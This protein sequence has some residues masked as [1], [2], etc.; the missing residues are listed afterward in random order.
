MIK[1][2]INKKDDKPLYV[3]IRDQLEQA[4]VANELKPGDKLPSVAVLAKEIGVTQATIRRALEDLS[5]KGYTKCHVGRGT[6][7]EDTKRTAGNPEH[8][9]FSKEPQEI[10]GYGLGPNRP[11]LRY[12]ARRMRR[13]VSEGLLELMNLAQQQGL[14]S[15]A[16]GIPDPKLHEPDFLKGLVN[17]AFK[18]DPLKYMAYSDCQGLMEL[19]CEIASRY[20]KKG[21]SVS[22]EQILITN[23]SQQAAAL[24]A[25]ET[26][27]KKQP[28]ICEAPSF[29]GI[30]ETFLA[31]GN[32]VDTVR[33]D[34]KGP[35]PEYL[36]HFTGHSYLLY[37]CPELHN[38][39]GTDMS[40]NRH[41]CIVKW[42]QNTKSTLLVDDIFQD[43]R[44]GDSPCKSF[45]TTLGED[46]TILI[47]SLSKTVMSGLRVGWMISS[48]E[49]IRAFTRLKRLMDQTC[50]PLMQGIVTKLFQTGK[51]DDH[52]NRILSIYQDR[53]NVMIESLKQLM[54]ESVTWTSPEGGFSL[55][56]TLPEGYSS[57]ALLLAAVDKGINF[58]PGP[59]FDIDQRFVKSFRLTWA[60][61]NKDEI[62]EGI[63]ILA[64]T[65]KELLRHSPGNLG[66]SG[67]GNFQ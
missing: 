45:I 10:H 8:P 3:Q 7:I 43:L 64:D 66:L 28:V 37:V 58:L 9:F 41:D 51:Y 29:Q 21:I 46:Q 27:E 44:F 31:H 62:A 4:I 19:R 12:A 54:P 34:E 33:R 5:K 52:L 38:P 14:I 25:M 1:I 36:N 18:E 22:P 42:A 26:A 20:I 11:E 17:D 24:V 57:I 63:E 2:E 65:V 60:W 30:T 35:N 61:V 55:W 59:L 50:P 56:V 6:F 67:L 48:P 15:F 39:I 32:W 16:K 23:G 53:K 49:R 13:G 47:S 40:S